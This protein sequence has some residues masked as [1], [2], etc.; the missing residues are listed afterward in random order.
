MSTRAYIRIEKDGEQPVHFHHHCDGYPSG[1][2]DELSG[3]LREYTG[4]WNPQAIGKYIN[5]RDSDYH[6]IEK[7]PA[8][9]H[10]YVYV[11]NCTE[12]RLLCY[13]KGISDDFDMEYPG[14]P[15]ELVRCYFDNEAHTESFDWSSFR[16]EVAM[17]I[18]AGFAAK[19]GHPMSDYPEQSCKYA[20]QLADEL[21]KQ[22]KEKKK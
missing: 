1:V 20:I 9:D 3:W 16:R 18:L 21:I 12:R 22:L 15:V 14:D 6:F 4:E 11:I 5:D 10:E 19:I 7:G 17:D 2:G 8:W 13:Y